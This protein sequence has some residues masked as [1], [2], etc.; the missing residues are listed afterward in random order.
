MHSPKPGLYDRQNPHNLRQHLN[1]LTCNLKSGSY[2]SQRLIPRHFLKNKLSIDRGNLAFTTE[3]SDIS[4][5][6][7]NFIMP[8]I[9][10]QSHF[11]SVDL[12]LLKSLEKPASQISADL[13]S[14]ATIGEN[15]LCA[16]VSLHRSNIVVSAAEQHKGKETRKITYI[17]KLCI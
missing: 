7:P 4:Y 16:F 8:D 1:H 6:C 13:R 5:P 14:H 11:S 10:K 17:M 15:G 9:S 3:P 12:I 2:S